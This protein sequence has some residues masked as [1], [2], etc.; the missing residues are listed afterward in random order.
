M[1]QPTFDT[2]AEDQRA[3]DEFGYNDFLATMDGAPQQADEVGA[4]QLTQLPPDLTAVTVGGRRS[5]T[6]GRRSDTGC[7]RL[8]AGSHDDTVSRPARTAG[9]QGT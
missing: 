4:S 6:G 8:V 5:D 7:Y 9:R 3:W 1:F 2:A